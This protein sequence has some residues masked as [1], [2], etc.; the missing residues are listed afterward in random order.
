[1]LHLS[2][3]LLLA[4]ALL[5]FPVRAADSES[6][7]DKL[8]KAI[9]L[10]VLDDLAGKP[11]P[12]GRLA[13]AR[14]V[15]VVFLSFDCPVSNSY[16]PELIKLAEEY[17][18][19]G[20]RFLGVCCAAEPAEKLAGLAKEFRLPF[21]VLHDPKRKAADALKATTTPEV[22]VLDH[23][24]VLRYRGRIDDAYYARLKKS[25]R[26][27]TRRDLREALDD[28]L[29][30]KPVRVPATEPIG[31]S[32]RL[33]ERAAGEVTTPYTFHRDVLPIL[34]KNCQGC[35]RPGA[36]GPFALMTYRHAL[37]WAEDI[38]RYTQSRQMPP[39]KPVA[40]PEFLNDRRMSQKEID[41]LASWADGGAPE[42][43]PK[44]APPPA[45]F[46]KG[47]QLG[48]PDLVLTVPEEFHLGPS[49]SDLFRCFV[50]PTGLTEDRYVVAFEVRP[51]NPRVV[52]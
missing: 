9:D 6:N 35:H 41:V 16:A 3:A 21:P 20:V 11:F 10:P 22:F 25:A 30:G 7:V 34:Q 49:G 42:G 2:S 40:G 15:A 18:E 23:N 28:V 13:D 37:N 24:R 19:R 38:K 50:L 51:G 26:G 31:C 52:H 44:D 33:E 12:P 1:M 47:W 17:G 8:G 48:E 39:W 29:A 46:A 14:A 43:D 5:T 32:L 4:A 36:V 27:V 45:E